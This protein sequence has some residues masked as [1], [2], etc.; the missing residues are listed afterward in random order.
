M[1]DLGTL[2]MLDQGR[3]AEV[4]L[5]RS[6]TK[7]VLDN[8]EFL[9][10]FLTCARQDASSSSSLP[11]TPT[12]IFASPCHPATVLPS[13]SRESPAPLLRTGG[14]SSSD[15]AKN[16][17]TSLPALS[18][19][20]DYL[21]PLRSY[22]LELNKYLAPDSRIEICKLSV[23]DRLPFAAASSDHLIFLCTFIT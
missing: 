7:T 22:V 8:H 13:P 2:A 1:A 9:P 12:S 23:G 10:R 17:A 15:N 18:A 14:A 20:V 19:I 3:E 4:V 21:L 6:G 16:W 5:T 11:T